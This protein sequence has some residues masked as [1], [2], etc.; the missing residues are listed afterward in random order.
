MKMA[1]LALLFLPIF[2]PLLSAQKLLE[3]VESK[4]YENVIL[5]DQDYINNILKGK[6]IEKIIK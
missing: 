5:F 2:S 4:D 3:A 6:A 1:I